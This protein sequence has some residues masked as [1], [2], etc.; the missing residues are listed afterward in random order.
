MNFSQLTTCQ[1]NI[2]NELLTPKSF[3]EIRNAVNLSISG[4]NYHSVR[5]YDHLEVKS[6]IELVC[7]YMIYKFKPVGDFSFIRNLGTLETDVFTLTIKGFTVGETATMLGL[8]ETKIRYS[9]IKI[10][11]V[12]GVSDALGLVFKCYG[13]DI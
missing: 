5:I 6:R 10:Y 13:V 7:E 12:A 1:L 9:R 4:L 2:V 8:Q 3:D 11:K